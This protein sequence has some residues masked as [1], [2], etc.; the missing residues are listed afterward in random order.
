[1]D[2]IRKEI[3]VLFDSEEACCGCAACQNICPNKAIVMKYSKTGFFYPEIDENR[4]LKCGM[5]LSVCVYK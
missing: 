2:E 4:C 3:P 5:C 1:M